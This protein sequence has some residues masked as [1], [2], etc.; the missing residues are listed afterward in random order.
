MKDG[1]HLQIENLHA[2][3]DETEILK[4]VSLSIEEGKLTVLMGPNGSG[5]T[6][7]ALTLLGS[8]KY[9]IAKGTIKIGSKS[10][11]GL[12][13]EE[14]AKEGLFLSFQ[15]PP[16]ISGVSIFQFL[17]ASY[18]SLNKKQ[19]LS[20][21]EAKN[22]F[23]EAAEKISLRRDFLVKNLNENFSGGEKK[24]VEALQLLVLNPK[25]A[26]IDEIDSGLDIDAVITV[27]KAI[28]SAKEKG[29]GILLVTHYRRILNF[30]SP[31]NVAILKNGK[32]VK[33]GDKSL[34]EDIESKGY[35]Q[36]F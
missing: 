33:T 13:P 11:V 7:L 9:K 2:G 3:T 32:I 35:E 31:E 27:A 5:K 18:N 28:N 14:R 21:L 29:T 22:R 16:S 10:L 20:V 34:I 19:P 17:R 36:F 4:G 30:L 26:I 1:K 6:T 24:K 23:E 15:N 25:F 12:T 8:P